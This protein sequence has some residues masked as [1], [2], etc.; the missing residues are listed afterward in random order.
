MI[1]SESGSRR[2]LYG[3]QKRCVL[4]SHHDWSSRL[5]WNACLLTAALSGSSSS[6]DPAGFTWKD[7]NKRLIS[8]T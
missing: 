8:L 2:A 3:P 5:G 1:R 6:R 7:S 4:A